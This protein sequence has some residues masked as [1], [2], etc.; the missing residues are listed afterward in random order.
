MTELSNA[1]KDLGNNLDAALALGNM[2]L[3]DANIEWVQGLFVN[4]HDRM[5]AEAMGVYLNC[6]YE[7]IRAHLDERGKLLI[8]WFRRLVTDH[9]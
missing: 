8:K 1:N 2:D 5:P 4:N 3:L 6:Y 9:N 7:G